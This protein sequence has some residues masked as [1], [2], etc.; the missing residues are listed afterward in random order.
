MYVNRHL[1]FATLYLIAGLAVM[2]VSG[3]GVFTWQSHRIGKLTAEVATLKLTQKQFEE[4]LVYNQ[5]QLEYAIDEVESCAAK[6]QSAEDR[7]NEA[8][9]ALE[10]AQRVAFKRSQKRINEI[11]EDNKVAVCSVPVP[12]RTVELLIAAAYNAN[13]GTDNP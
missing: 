3:I 7:A 12:S 5:G 2:A 8:S 10:E 4:A 9:V 13:S 6:R 1:G 11:Q